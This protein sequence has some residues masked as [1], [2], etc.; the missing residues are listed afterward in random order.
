ME[1]SRYLVSGPET[2]TLTLVLAHGAG[3][4]MNHPSMESIAQRLA[5]RG[6]RTVRFEFPY[7][8]A[9]KEGV[10]R[11]P[12][13]APRLMET[14]LEVIADQGDPR[15]LVIGGRSMGGRIASMV[16]D[17]SGVRGLVCLGYPFHP[18]R[19]PTVLRVAHLKDL[20]TP[21][22][23]IQGTRD[24][25]GRPEEIAGYELSRAI[26]IHSLEDGD[27]SFAPR[28]ASGRTIDQ[29]NDEAVARIIEF[30]SGLSG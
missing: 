7:M 4:G 8:H 19:R 26:T 18:A 23:I 2:S 1:Q 29:N 20:A 5:L 10:R 22:L 24:D 25:L 30:I 27:H 13:P 9:R 15:H 12:D 17:A 16:A 11:G 14:W 28:K 6:V 3:A 21:T